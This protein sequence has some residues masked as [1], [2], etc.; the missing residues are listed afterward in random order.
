MLRREQGSAAAVEGIISRLL[1]CRVGM[2]LSMRH[3]VCHP[4]LLWGP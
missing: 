3:L 1:H 4:W 2:H